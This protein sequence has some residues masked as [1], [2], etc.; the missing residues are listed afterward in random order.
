MGRGKVQLKRIEN[1]NARKVTFT[2]R[3]DSLLRKAFEFSLL[4]EVDVAA[5]IF[6]SSDEVYEYSTQELILYISVPTPPTPLSFPITSYH[7][8]LDI[9]LQ[10]PLS[11][12]WQEVDGMNGVIHRGIIQLPKGRKAVGCK[13]VFKIKKRLNGKLERYRMTDLGPT[14]QILWIEIERDRQN[15]KESDGLARQGNVEK[16]RVISFVEKRELEEKIGG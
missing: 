16:K 10:S 6:S 2:K 1:P 9:F 8:E 14:R 7:L 4:C 5:I 12:L 13:W 3:R 15:R 11:L